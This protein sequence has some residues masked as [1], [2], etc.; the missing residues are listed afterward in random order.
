MTKKIQVGSLSIGGGERIK[1]QS[2]TTSK[3]S[4]VDSTVAQIL[5]LQNAG[6]DLV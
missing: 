2:M 3:T 6:C 5:R 1:I 4:D